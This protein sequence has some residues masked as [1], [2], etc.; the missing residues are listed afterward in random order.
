M[1]YTGE[2]QAKYRKYR[3]LKTPAMFSPRF[4]TE[5]SLLY[6]WATFALVIILLWIVI[7]I[8]G[9][10]AIHEFLRKTE[11]HLEKSPTDQLHY[12]I[13]FMLL[14][15]ESW[16][17]SACAQKRVQRETQKIVILRRYTVFSA[18][19]VQNELENPR[20]GPLLKF[21]GKCH[22]HHFSD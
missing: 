19:Q 14:L 4:D 21:Q 1:L 10:T 16:I 9:A 20:E 7:P 2:W 13:S 8:G 6:T 5:F 22:G 18:F 12:W 3:K 15:R 11:M 17:Y